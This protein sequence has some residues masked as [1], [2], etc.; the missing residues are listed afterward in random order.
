M[1]SFQQKLFNNLNNVHRTGF[2]GK[3]ITFQFLFTD[4]YAPESFFIGGIQQYAFSVFAAHAPALRCQ[5]YTVIASDAFGSLLNY[6]NQNGLIV[7]YNLV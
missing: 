5:F 2:G 7:L 4:S 1:S 6:G 3:Q